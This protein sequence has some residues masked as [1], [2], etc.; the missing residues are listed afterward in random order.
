[1]SRKDDVK[2]LFNFMIELLREDE[3]VKSEVF[4]KIKE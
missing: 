2:L 3:E 1:M 4:E